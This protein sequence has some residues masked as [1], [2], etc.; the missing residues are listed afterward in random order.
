MT[1]TIRNARHQLRYAPPP[2]ASRHRGGIALALPASDPTTLADRDVVAWIQTHFYIP[3]T[4]GPLALAPYQQAVLRAA[5]PPD[6]I[7]LPYSTVVWGDIKKS[8]KS[9]LAAAVCLWWLW[10][11]DQRDGYGSAYII[12][13]DL[14]QADS[15]I[16]YY[17]RR[18]IDLNP[19]LRSRCKVTP[20]KYK[21]TLPNQSFIEAIPIDPTGEAGSNADAVFFSELWGAHSQAQQRMWTEATLSPTKYGQSF[22]WVETYAGYTGASPLLEQLYTQTVVHGRVLDAAIE[23]YDHPAARMLTLWNTQPRLPWQTKEYYAQ[24]QAT[25]LPS[26]YQRVHRNQWS[27][28]SSSPFLPDITLWDACADP[29]LPPLG[30]HEPCV[31][32]VDAGESNDCFAWALVSRHPTNVLVCAVR[33]SRIYTPTPGIALDFDAIEFDLRNLGM[34]Y[35]IQRLV[36]D[37]MLLGQM[38]RRLQAPAVLRAADGTALR[39]Y[40][41]FPAPL[42]V[43]SQGADRLEADKGLLDAITQRRLLHAG[44]PGLLRDHVRNADR[45]VSPTGLRIVKRSPTLKIDG[46]VALSMGHAAAL[47]L[48]VV[49][50]DAASAS[51]LQGRRV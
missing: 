12:A 49:G 4:R 40:P 16:A 13:N 44:G 28:G 42:V 18:A 45:A 47:T 17:L 8:A 35:A 3:E 48:P 34:A 2:V 50:W 19:T 46:A 23:L 26:E 25:L 30:P 39:Q 5:F 38:V 10:Q 15:R 22:R 20:G 21:V 9:T 41:A 24:E 11:V 1:Y 37:R 6:A 32:A 27:D 51:A 29:N 31:L 14:K 7:T 36:Y 33:L 43:F